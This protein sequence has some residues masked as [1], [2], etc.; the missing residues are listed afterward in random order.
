MSTLNYHSLPEF[1][2]LTSQGK[3]GPNMHLDLRNLNGSEIHRIS[4]NDHCRQLCA[5]EKIDP[6]TLFLMIKKK[7][8][9]DM[10]Y[11]TSRSPLFTKKLESVSREWSEDTLKPYDLFNCE[12]D[13][14]FDVKIINNENEFVDHLENEFNR[15]NESVKDE[16]SN[17]YE[18][19][20]LLKTDCHDCSLRLNKH[21]SQLEENKEFYEP[22]YKHIWSDLS[23][24]QKVSYLNDLLNEI[25]DKEKNQ[26]MIQKINRRVDKD[27]P[28][29]IH[30]IFL[31]GLL[32]STMLSK[33]NESLKHKLIKLQATINN[34]HQQ[35]D[36]LLQVLPDPALELQGEATFIESLQ[37][38][39]RGFSQESSDEDDD[40]DDLLGMDVVTGV[41]NNDIQSA[42]GNI[43]DQSI[44]KNMDATES[45]NHN[46]NINDSDDSDDSDDS[47]SQMSEKEEMYHLR[48]DKPNDKP[49]DNPN[50]KP[51]QTK[52][53][54]FD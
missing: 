50:K 12:Y 23:T 42:M 43:I 32:I 17:L 27:I 20:Q 6:L 33:E 16:D 3:I 18:S 10:L 19:L 30:S 41:T 39:F 38:I 47:S 34:R 7:I 8:N 46:H 28:D 25:K 52:P 51:N 9:E 24:T 2:E 21:M 49:N 37:S 26:H 1:V 4:Y 45:N 13:N 40:D 11:R 31:N 54:F 48:I 29:Q 22:K 14:P 35:I 15:L 36:E 5:G 44:A 53:F